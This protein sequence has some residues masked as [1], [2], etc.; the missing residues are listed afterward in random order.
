IR[1]RS[2][3]DVLDLSLHVIR[4]RAA[5]L[6]IALAVGIVPLFLLNTYLL[7]GFEE[8]DLHLPI[9]DLDVPF[10]YMLL[11]VFLVLWEA[12]L[13]T[14]PATLYLGQAVFERRP[15]AS[16]VAS[17]LVKSI[18]QLILYQVLSRAMLLALLV[19]WLWLFSQ[20]AYLNEVILLERNPLRQKS[21]ANPSTARRCRMLHTGISGDLLLRWMGSTAFGIL[22][23][24]SFWGA[25]WILRVLLLSQWG[26]ENTLF[27]HYFQ[28]ALWLVA[29]FFGVARFLSYLD[30]RIRREGWE[31]ELVMR[32]E[33]ERLAGPET[34]Y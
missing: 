8:P 34:I 33:S 30:L 9:F 14:A 22:L 18:P 2:F 13:A 4:W 23:V 12:P 19:T 10:R 6:T 27:T 1:E 21:P 29:G 20:R 24:A 16:R 3:L 11:M 17:D 26:I 28:V 25:M 31:I 15:S 32:A 5:P 7:S